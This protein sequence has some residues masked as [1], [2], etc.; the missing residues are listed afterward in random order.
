MT[1]D[2]MPRINELSKERG[3]LFRLATN[4]HRG[5]PEIQRRVAEVTAELDGLW[6]LRRRER[7]GRKG[8]IDRLIDGVY[9]RLYGDDYDA[10]V[11]P[12]RVD[13]EEGTSPAVAA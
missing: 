4:G 1:T 9:Q 2:T 5:D 12:P 7:V 11:S 13:A 6:D 3:E 8:A 10:A